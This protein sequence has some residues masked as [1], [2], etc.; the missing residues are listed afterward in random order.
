M[1]SHLQSSADY[2]R[3]RRVFLFRVFSLFLLVAEAELFFCRA[4]GLLSSIII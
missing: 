1:Q 3:E 2:L 4:N